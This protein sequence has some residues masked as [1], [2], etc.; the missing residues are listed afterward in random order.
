MQEQSMKIRAGNVADLDTVLALMDEAVAWL[1]A[2]GRTDQW[3]SEPFSTN[4]KTTAFIKKL[5]DEGDLFIAERDGET[6]GALIVNEAPMPYVPTV[7]ERELYVR[8]L[9]ASRRYKGAGIGAELVEFAREEAR[10]RGIELLRVDCYSG[11][12]EKLVRFYESA[13]F[14]RTQR[15][16]VRDDI[17]VQVFEDRIRAAR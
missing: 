7:E 12:D 6:A 1:A 2:Q 4:P 8:L 10:K 3:G 13:G 16:N 9:V 11:P 5:V 17:Y 15:I 14:T